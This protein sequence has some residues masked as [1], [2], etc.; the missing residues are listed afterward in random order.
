[1]AFLYDSLPSPRRL[2]TLAFVLSAYNCG[3]VGFNNAD[4]KKLYLE[5]YFDSIKQIYSNPDAMKMIRKDKKTWM[6]LLCEQQ[7]LYNLAERT[8]AKV[9]NLL[10]EGKESYKK[11]IDVGYQHLLGTDKWNMLDQ[12]KL[13]LFHINPGIY[14]D[15][16]K[17]LANYL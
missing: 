12:I 16:C 7:H 8:N 15:T 14:T 11:A 5:S 6:D 13:Q 4:F 2:H 17:K 9:C 3:L 10:G 1:M